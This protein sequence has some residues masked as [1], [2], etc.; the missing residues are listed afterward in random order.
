M[1]GLTTEAMQKFSDAPLATCPECGS[2]LRKLIS[3]SSFVLKGTGWYKTDYADKG[4]GTEKKSAARKD[5]GSS[6]ETK[7]ESGTDS[8]KEAKPEAKKEPAPAS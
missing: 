3:N 1:C 2:R 5:T 4:S 6:T 8:K 7:T